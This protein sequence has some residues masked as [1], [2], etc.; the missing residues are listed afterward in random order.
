M[1]NFLLAEKSS[2]KDCQVS[3]DKII[4]ILE[5]NGCSCTGVLMSK[6]GGDEQF[7]YADPALVPENTD[8]VIALGGDGTLIHT[9]KDLRT[10]DIPIFGVNCGTLGYLT[11]GDAEHF[12]DALQAILDYDYLIEE[13]IMMEGLIRHD[14]RI[15]HRGVALNDI[16]LHKSIMT[17]LANFD[18]IVDGTFLNRYAADGIILSTPMGSTGYNLSAGGP[19]V[20]P[21]SKI[22][23][24][25]PISAHTLNSRSIV[26]PADVEVDVVSDD[27]REDDN[28]Q[29]VYAQFDGEKPILLQNGDV[30]RV[31]VADVRIKMIRTNKMSFVENLGRKMR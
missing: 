21:T 17:S 4:K 1:K 13:H 25:T 19:V 9:A 30:L 7:V 18:V 5:K 29:E 6:E 12:E 16:V 20:L 26:F 8:A 15:V 14:D 22:I 11:E 31:R 10:L 3:A 23:L 28:H 2:K 27:R 24:V